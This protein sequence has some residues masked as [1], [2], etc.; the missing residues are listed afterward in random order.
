MQTEQTPQN[1]H[2]EFNQD[3]FNES[4]DEEPD[5]QLELFIDMV[6]DTNLEKITPQDLLPSQI[7]LPKQQ[8]VKTAKGPQRPKKE[9]QLH[10]L[11]LEKMKIYD[12]LL[13]EN[14]QDFLSKKN[15][16]RILTKTGLL[17]ADGFIVNLPNSQFLKNRELQLKNQGATNA[18]IEN[19][20]GKLKD[21][22][23]VS[24]YYNKN[25]ESRD[26]L[27]RKIFGNKNKIVQ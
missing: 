6:L 16:R 2:D 19:E 9:F 18:K 25:W 24:P 27:Y 23:K 22:H 5:E 11:I 26:K 13:D 17:N 8:S 21:A 10:G 1:E 12:G 15:R 14:L 20:T 3:A 7:E 4:F